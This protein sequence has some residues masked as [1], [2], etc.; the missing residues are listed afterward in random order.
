MRLTLTAGLVWLAMAVASV[1]AAA[2][3]T[4]QK[5]PATQTEIPIPAYKDIERVVSKH[6]GRQPDFQPRD[7]ITRDQVKPLLGQLK[8]LGLPLADA[9]QILELVPAK[10]EFL[11]DQLSTPA[12]RR[13][14]RDASEYPGAYD[15]LDRLSRMIHGKQ[16][17]RDLIRGPDGYKMIEY[18]TTAPGGKSLGK[19]LSKAPH[20][21]K[22]N[23]PTGRIYTVDMLLAR[24]EESRQAAIAS[25]AKK[26]Q[27]AKQQDSS[28]Q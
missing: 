26:A 8:R 5:P 13:F 16:T 10:G 15:R 19:M 7:L 11:V 18:M 17:L 14:M 27:N 2:Q 24:L 9:D 21:G 23:E 12:G 28:D 20:A 3:D 4:V 25:A 22:F 1:V 6:F